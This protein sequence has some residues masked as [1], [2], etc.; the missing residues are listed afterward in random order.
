MKLSPEIIRERM[1]DAFKKDVKKF[2]KNREKQYMTDFKAKVESGE[3]DIT[4]PTY[5]ED[6]WERAQEFMDLRPHE[7]LKFIK[8]YVNTNFDIIADAVSEGIMDKETAEV[9]ME[10]LKYILIAGEIEADPETKLK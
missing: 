7:L 2:Y 5:K 1:F 9:S 4:S 6:A 10:V 8:N 3:I